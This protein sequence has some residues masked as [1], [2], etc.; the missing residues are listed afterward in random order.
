MKLQL[1]EERGEF[2]RAV[3]GT[4]GGE[5]MTAGV[6]TNSFQREK[7]KLMRDNIEEDHGLIPSNQGSY[8][9]LVI[10]GVVYLMWK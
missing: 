8:G 9:L 3:P 7:E 4:V 10:L 1:A 2:S 5:A 6:Q